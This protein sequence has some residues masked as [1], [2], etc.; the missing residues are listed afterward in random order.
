[1][2][3][4]APMTPAVAQVTNGAAP[5][6]VAT[7]LPTPSPSA[8]AAA[9]PIPAAPVIVLPTPTPT[10]VVKPTPRATPSPVATRTPEPTP[11]PT[12]TASPSV[13]PSP[14]AAPSPTPLATAS[15]IAPAPVADADTG[16]YWLAGLAIGVVALGALAWVLLRRRRADPDELPI[17]GSP[18]P[19]AGAPRARLTIGFRP[20]RAG[21][22]LLSATSE[23]EIV[24]T[25]TGDAA[26]ED[27][28]LQVRLVSAHAG[29]DAELAG[30]YAEPIGRPTVPAFALAPGEARTIV[31]VAA[32]PRTAIRTLTAAGRPMFVPIVA[33]NVTYAGDGAAAQV[34]QAFAVGI[35]RVDS[36]KLA[37][38]WLDTPP[39]TYDQVAARPHAAPIER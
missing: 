7:P 35:E 36:A 24:L 27:V 37:P 16:R 20:I 29:Q 22:N 25:N 2:G 12:P 19:V 5:A 38:F 26:A 13:D 10:P 3:T 18:A 21:V 6:V 34:A 14:V 30:F 11:T 4:V 9:L 32:L 17:E 15:P 23:N 28:R 33:V 31:A 39:R 8:T 1:M